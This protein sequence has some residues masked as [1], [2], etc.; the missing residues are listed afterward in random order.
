MREL[1]CRDSLSRLAIIKC[2]CLCC[3]GSQN[4]RHIQNYKLLLLSDT[5]SYYHYYCIYCCFTVLHVFVYFEWTGE[6]FGD[7]VTFGKLKQV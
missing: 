3:V 4:G 6:C 5:H 7:G 1:K 2:E